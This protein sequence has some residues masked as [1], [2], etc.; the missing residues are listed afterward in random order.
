VLSY[1]LL[2]PLLILNRKRKNRPK[3]IKKQLDLI[4]GGHLVFIFLGSFSN[5]ILPLIFNIYLFNGLGPAFALIL[6]G[7]YFYTISRHDFLNI[8]IAAQRS[9][10]YSGLLGIIIIFYLGLIFLI[11]DVLQKTANTAIIL[12][13]GLTTIFGIFSVPAIEK[14]FKKLTDRIFFKNR[15]DY[16]S[17]I[18]NLS[19]VLNE[20]NESSIIISRTSENLKKLIRSENIIFLLWQQKKLFINGLEQKEL[21]ADD[22]PDLRNYNQMG[23]TPTPA[24]T[25]IDHLGLKNCYDDEKW[26]VSPINLGEKKIASILLTP[27]LSGN[28]FLPDDLKLIKTFAL[29]AAVALEKARLLE[30][31]KK[32]ARE[33]EKKVE[34]RTIK[35][36]ELQKEQQ[37][38]M[39]EVSHELQTPLTIIKIGLEKL[40]QGQ[41]DGLDIKSFEKSIDWISKYT[42]DLLRLARMELAE[43]FKR[44]ELDLSK[45][46][47]DLAEYYDVMARGQ[48]IRLEHA[49]EPGVVVFAD[50]TK[51][52]ELANILMSNAIKYIANE[53][54]ISLRLSKQKNRIEMRLCDS[55]IGIKKENLKNI[56]KQ[57]FMEKRIDG[58]KGS[59]LGLA[60]AKKIVET[61]N[62]TISV[63]S[64]EG[65]GSCFIVNLPVIKNPR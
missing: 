2:S 34:Q 45:I 37:K 19:R 59:G 15:Y 9:L 46:L 20:N 7:F 40:K 64:E 48:G 53:K 50:R 44:E 57:F 12:S 60:M 51:M 4:F 52:E 10:I 33:L 49:I 8:K 36:N 17:A 25:I 62:G 27:P 55:G 65:Q 24:T 32:H 61:H 11:G 28:G 30:K 42:Y 3:I 43:N 38:M 1:Y 58:P 29:Q 14:Y 18:D 21:T 47:E 54:K 13:A 26:L 41:P 63:E 5:Y 23:I 16:S 35:I 31:E 56:F 39:L 6:A 22:W